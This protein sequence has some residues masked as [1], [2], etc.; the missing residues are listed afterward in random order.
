MR[1][2]NFCVTVVR[3]S[4][5][6]K[7]EKMSTSAVLFRVQEK[8]QKRTSDNWLKVR[9]SIAEYLSF[10]TLQSLEWNMK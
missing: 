8:R 3:Q 10:K 6:E 7:N 9:E 1:I 5:T 2:G 4:L